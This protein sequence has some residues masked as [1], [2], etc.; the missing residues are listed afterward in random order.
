[1][2]GPSRHRPRR[3]VCEGRGQHDNRTCMACTARRPRDVRAFGSVPSF[4]ACGLHCLRLSRS[5]G[6]AAVSSINSIAYAR[7]V[8]YSYSKH[9]RA[10]LNGLGDVR[11]ARGHPV[12]SCKCVTCY[13]RLLPSLNQHGEMHPE[14][15][16][17][18][19]QPPTIPTVTSSR[20]ERLG[21]GGG[22]G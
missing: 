13:T 11:N 10:S 6:I 5:I 14:Q 7:V 3:S 17:N 9:L 20:E 19:S 18:T 4:C 2:R 22:G 1:M 12:Q 15:D 21:G 8:L 16:E